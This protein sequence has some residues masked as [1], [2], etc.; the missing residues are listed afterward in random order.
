MSSLLGEVNHYRYPGN[1]S[2]LLGEVN[3]YRYPGNM[4]SLLG[5]VNNYTVGEESM[6]R[7][8][9]MAHRRF[10]SDTA[11]SVHFLKFFF[12]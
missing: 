6:A 8:E 1:M 3:N 4:S 5:E 9:S 10:A 7:A 11:A 2:S 12:S